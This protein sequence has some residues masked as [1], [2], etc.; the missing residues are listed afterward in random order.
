MTTLAQALQD[1]LDKQ[2]S[3]SNTH[4]IL[5]GL[6][7]GDRRI[8]FRGSAGTTANVS[9]FTASITKMFTAALVL[10]LKDSGLLNLDATVQSILP[11]YDLS[12]LHTVKTTAYG[13]Q[14]TVRQ[15]LHQ[16]SGLADYYEGD[17][18]RALKRGEDQ[19]YD[20]QDVLD[21]TK[22][23]PPQAAPDSG[24]SWYSDTNYQLLGA[25][26]E[27]VTAQP[28]RA[29]LQAQI[30]APLGLKQTGVFD[31]TELQAMA[32]L[33]LYHKEKALHLPLALSSMDPDG[34]I[35]STLDDMLV[36]LRAYFANDL[37]SAQNNGAVRQFNPLFF[38]LQYGFGLM[39]FK[40][41]RWM[42]LFRETPELIGHSGSSGSFAFYAPRQDLY[43]VG[44]FNQIDAPRRPFGFMMQALNLVEKYSTTP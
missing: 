34:G 36:F 39:R 44:T 41:P 32:P 3:K 16:T 9:F 20:L 5:F 33:A 43:L 15:L 35:V 19:A 4:T 40:L 42:N 25:I 31:A 37:Y 11:H 22:V 1:L 7:S 8:D 29:V 30:A 24:K 21:M 27:A 2:A 38:P 18:A 23:L 14:L 6:Q 17:L 10:Q 12:D 26:I 13:P 28:Y